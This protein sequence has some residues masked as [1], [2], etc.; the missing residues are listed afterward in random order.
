MER[1]TPGHK[2]SYILT[3]VFG[4]RLPEEKEGQLVSGSAGGRQS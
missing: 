1:T 3:S 2:Y 4:P